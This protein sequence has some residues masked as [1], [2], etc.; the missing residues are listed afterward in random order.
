MITS[1]ISALYALTFR[2][3]CAFGAESVTFTS[4]VADSAEFTNPGPLYVGT[5][6][7]V[8]VLCNDGTTATF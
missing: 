5:A 8:S 6:G 4:G 7:D 1:F 3:G 2:R